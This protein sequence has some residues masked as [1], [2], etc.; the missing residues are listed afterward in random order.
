V[1]PATGFHVASVHSI[2]VVA[3]SSAPLFPAHHRGRV[4]RK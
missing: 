4:E 2:L 3:I 1:H